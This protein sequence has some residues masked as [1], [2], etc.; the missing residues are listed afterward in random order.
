M[1]LVER[2][3]GFEVRPTSV[4][5]LVV[6]DPQDGWHDR[7]ELVLTLA[8]GNVLDALFFPCVT[9]ARETIDGWVESGLTH[10]A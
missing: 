1:E 7:A 6:V 4:G 5:H 8:S 10:P 9:S 2:Y 3:R